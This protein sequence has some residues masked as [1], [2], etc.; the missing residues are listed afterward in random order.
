MSKSLKVPPSEVYGIEAGS[1]E[2]YAMNAAVVRWG[3]AYDAAV[4]YATQDAKDN[5]AAR[6]AADRVTRRWIP[7]TRRYADPAKR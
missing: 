7:E 2:A 6:A 5:N 3:T 1:L 4:A